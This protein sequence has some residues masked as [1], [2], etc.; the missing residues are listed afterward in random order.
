MNTVAPD[1]AGFATAVAALKT[2]EVVAYPTE[3]VY[4]LGVN[5]FSEN[6][7]DR[8]YRV[9]HRD[10]AH[11]VLILIGAPDQ[12]QPLVKAITPSAR[13][14][15]DAF[16]PGPLSLLFT[17]ATA[18]P[19]RLAGPDGRICVRLT[20][21]PVAARLAREF[22]GGITSTSANKTGVAPARSAGDVPADGVCVCIDGGPCTGST[23]STIYDSESGTILREGAVSRRE[24]DAA[25]G[26]S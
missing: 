25:L 1:D 13:R 21:H 2:D 23:V 7:L 4:G 5:P 20:S 3:T 26:N 12:L 14:C 16:W 6:A 24:L 10:P 19:P 9:K 8:V 18:V 11:P 22:G 17:P 15:M